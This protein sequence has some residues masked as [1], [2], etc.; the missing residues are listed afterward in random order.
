VLPIQGPPGAGKTFLAAHM[1]CSLARERRKVGVTGPNHKVIRNLLDTVQ[2]VARAEGVNVRCIHKISGEIEDEDWPIKQ[3]ND[4]GEALDALTSGEA[5]VA[6]G[7]VWMWSR[8]DFANVAD[9]LFVDEAGQMSLA[10]VV[11]AGRGAQNIVLLGDPQQLEQPLQGSHPEGSAVSALQH[12]LG[13]AKTM[14]PER[15]LFLPE[16]WRLAPRIT[17]YTSEMFYEGRL[18]SREGLEIQ[19]LVSDIE[20]KG[21]GLWYVPVDH[22]GNQNESPEEAAIVARIVQQLRDATLWINQRGE[23][24]KID[25]KDILIVAPYNA[26]VAAI[27]QLIPAAR[28][29]T[30]DRFQGQEAAVVIYSS[31]TSLPEDAPRGMEFL[32]SL[33]RLNVATSRA[34]CAV[35]V[36][37]SPLLFEPDCQT[38]RQMQLANALCRYLELATTVS[39]AAV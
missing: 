34:K 11:A 18:S 21:S 12:V 35:I 17:A 1:I 25:W 16:T 23:S 15:G 36:V 20:F 31:A 26:H 22:L 32:Y 30:V 13:D 5:H 38:P 27:Q 10:N 7:T 14:P 6:A 2:E 3:T 8:G 33:N 19:R 29:G 28:V 24:A 39:M 4:N 9:I 37:A